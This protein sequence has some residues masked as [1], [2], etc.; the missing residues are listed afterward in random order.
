MSWEKLNR[1]I[2]KTW[3]KDNDSEA[4]QLTPKEDENEEKKRG[5]WGNK[6]EF[7]LASIG[8]AVGLGN[9][10]RFPYLCQKN[11]GGAF[12]IPYFTMMIIEGIPLFYIEYAV[13]QRFKRS[14]IGCWSS[15]HPAL[16][17]VGISC[18]VTSMFLCIYY[19]IVIAWCFH[20]LFASF[21][22][23][24]PW[25]LENCPAYNEYKNL[26]DSCHS[27]KSVTDCSAMRNF[28][29]CCVHDP[30]LHYFY[31]KVLH[32]SP[33]LD[34]VGEGVQYKLFG[35][36]FAAWLICYICIVK[37]VQ[38]TG[39]AAYFTATFP[40]LILIILL[41]YGLTLEGAEIGLKALFK[42]DFKKVLEPEIWLDAAVQMFFTLSLGFG[43]LISFASYMP[44]KNNCVRD[45]YTVVLI[46]C[47]TSLFSAIVVFSILG[48]RAYRLGGEVDKIGGG[49]GLVFITFCDAFLQMPV[50]P[51]W[52]I[53]FFIML[54]LLGIGSEF[55]TLEGFITPFYDMNWVKIPRE[56][57]TGVV[58]AI[59]FLVGISFVSSPGYYLFQLF[60][61]Y[62]V[63]FGLVVIA[64]F[65]TIAISWVYG[66]DRFA[67]DIEYMTGK[68]P[69]LFWMICWKYIS[70]VAIFIIFVANCHQQITKG[71]TYMA[72]VGCAQQ[73][74]SFSPFGSGVEG[75][76][77]KVS[78][79]T[80]AQIFITVIILSAVSPIFIYLIK[81][82]VQN[83][84]K[85]RE[86][87]RKKFC[88]L[89]EYH[90]DP[91]IVD[92]SRRKSPEEIEI[93]I[94]KKLNEA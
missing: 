31:T 35:C 62:S 13:G 58:A 22:S 30:Q 23:K 18:L 29:S 72:Y 16:K 42:P 71:A 61:E 39:K 1:F 63:S 46:N 36:L 86:G 53:L 4:V 92:R 21:S 89:A 87:F 27:N 73:L 91:S 10:W 48:H 50:S 34:D 15:I 93:D 64:F 5:S 25:R 90:P 19:I 59:M 38:S 74:I 70:P 51:L 65:Q 33:S 80:W 55:G 41:V 28:S 54:I 32:V 11:G 67:D 3:K 6:V 88:T 49:P 60:D 77:K 9:I 26:S 2:L 83:P 75:S 84:T 17:G 43:A 20:Y 57:F 94:R 40:Y 37:G 52:S 66:T 81:D 44:I 7:I 14:A 76:I 47:A 45:A 78:H 85:W 56:I 8:I 24:L 79:S 68:R 69:Y 82:L 12:L